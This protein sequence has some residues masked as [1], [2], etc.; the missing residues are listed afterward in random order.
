MYILTQISARRYLICQTYGGKSRGN[1]QIYSKGRY[2]ES[3]EM[4]EVHHATSLTKPIDYETGME[5]YCYL[6]KNKPEE[7][8]PKRVADAL[9]EDGLDRLGLTKDDLPEFI[10]V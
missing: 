2:G 5:V 9:N 4:I 1:L 7:K 10:E 8:I 3:N 6:E